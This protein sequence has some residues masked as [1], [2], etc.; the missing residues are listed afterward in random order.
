MH[1][2]DRELDFRFFRIG[3]Q[4]GNDEILQKYRGKGFW[5]L[6]SRPI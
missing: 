2:K 1:N 3:M 6:N 5:T 4:I